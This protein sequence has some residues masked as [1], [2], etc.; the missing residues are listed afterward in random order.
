[1]GGERMDEAEM[2]RKIEM[3]LNERHELL[4][5][6]QRFELE[7]GHRV[8][9]KDINIELDRTWDLLRRYRAQRANGLKSGTSKAA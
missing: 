4:Q 5:K 1:M 8:R 9:I 6:A 7:D 3:L 2:L